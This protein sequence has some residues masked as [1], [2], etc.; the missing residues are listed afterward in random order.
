M[1]SNEYGMMDKIGQFF[2]RTG[3]DMGLY[4]G[5]ES[6][7]DFKKDFRANRDAFGAGE[8]FDFKGKKYTTD[9]AEDVAARKQ[10][11]LQNL[12]GKQAQPKENN[13]AMANAVGD[14]GSA[15]AG[16][17]QTIDT[18]LYS[19]FQPEDTMASMRQQVLQNMKMRG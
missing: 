16:P 11:A 9:T 13:K 4:D 8:E 12:S 6:T 18:G 19:T 15:L 5:P 14:L 3:R 10:E 17:T 2:K 7:G 1:M